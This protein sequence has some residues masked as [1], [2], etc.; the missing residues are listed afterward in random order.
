VND[1]RPIGRAN[2]RSGGGLHQ[3]ACQCK[4][5]E[6]MTTKFMVNHDNAWKI[7]ARKYK[8]WHVKEKHENS[9]HGML[10]KDK[11]WNVKSRQGNERQVM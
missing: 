5:R 7:M 8:E 4:E 2:P 9:R 10:G 6:C 3:K 11:A 1:S